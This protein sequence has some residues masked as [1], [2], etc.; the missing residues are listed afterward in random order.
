MTVEV[1][2]IVRAGNATVTYF[3]RLKL[4]NHAA[5]EC[6]NCKMKICTLSSSNDVSAVFDLWRAVANGKFS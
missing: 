5:D 1:E 6:V 2:E 4:Y 3:M